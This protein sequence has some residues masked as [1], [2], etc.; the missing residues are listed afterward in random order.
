MVER[1]GLEGSV[2]SLGY[3]ADADLAS[4]YAKARVVVMPSDAEGFGVPLL[5]AMAAGTPIVAADLPVVEEVTA[6][7]AYVFRPGDAKEAAAALT[8]AWSAPSV[9][10]LLVD[11]AQRARSWTWA[12]AG[13][14]LL[15]S[16]R[17]VGPEEPGLGK[18][19]PCWDTARWSSWGSHSLCRS[20]SSPGH[21]APR[22]GIKVEIGR[23]SG[24]ERV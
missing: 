4:W 7:T 3:V 19:F 6:G 10:S 24:R 11:R 18:S 2:R 22:N 16:V 14:Q 21:R 9:S 8:Q 23:A 20:S 5:E 17:R 15:Q 13:A 12:N 1:L